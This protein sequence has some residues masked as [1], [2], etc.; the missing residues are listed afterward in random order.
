MLLLLCLVKGDTVRHL[1]ELLL[2]RLVSHLRGLL[3]LGLGVLDVEGHRL[4]DRDA[5]LR[6]RDEV[7][8]DVV[9]IDDVCHYWGLLWLRDI[10]LLSID[11][12]MVI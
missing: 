1:S 12:F 9:I 6:R 3:W 7:V 10:S 8:I 11:N 5:C 4:F 2:G